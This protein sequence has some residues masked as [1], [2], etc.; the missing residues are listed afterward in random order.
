MYFNENAHLIFEDS[1]K[2]ILNVSLEY[3]KQKN[4]KHQLIEQHGGVNNE[5]INVLNATN[6][7]NKYN[8]YIHDNLDKLPE[9][10]KDLYILFVTVVTIQ[11]KFSPN[12]HIK[13]INVFCELLETKKIDFKNMSKE[14]IQQIFD[15]ALKQHDLDM[16]NKYKLSKENIFN[17]IFNRR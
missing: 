1:N 7:F 15:E 3:N 11:K 12:K 13:D 10:I 6:S 14:E 16:T 2:N 5:I 17:N 8:D 4:N 9:N